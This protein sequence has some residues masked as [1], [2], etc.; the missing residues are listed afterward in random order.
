MRVLHFLGT[1]ALA[2][3]GVTATSQNAHADAS[4]TALVSNV[5]NTLNQSGGYYDFE[6]TMH[7]TDVALVSYSSGT[8]GRSGNAS[9]PL[10]GSSNQLFSDR[11]SGNQPF[12]INAGDTLSPWISTSGVLYIY[13]NTWRFSTQWDMQCTGSTL[14]R[15]VPG[16]GVVSLTIRAWHPPIW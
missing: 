15:I 1:L 10:S 3:A 8:L 7:R 12:N 6:M 4:C 14:T 11:R 13:Y 2:L 5:A 9:W 16:F